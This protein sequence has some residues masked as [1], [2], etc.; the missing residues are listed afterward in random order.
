MHDEPIELSD[1]MGM[2]K[3]EVLYKHLHSDGICR[4]S[5]KNI[6]VFSDCGLKQYPGKLCVWGN[7]TKF[8]IR[9]EAFRENFEEYEPFAKRDYDS[10]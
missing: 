9:N 8:A 10:V 4:V 5:E 7:R 3:K 2:F 6:V 1:P